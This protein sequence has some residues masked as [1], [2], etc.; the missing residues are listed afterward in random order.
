M[1]SEE[2]IKK[3]KEEIRRLEE[4]NEKLKQAIINTAKDGAD[5]ATRIWISKLE[6]FKPINKNY[7]KR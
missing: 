5:V 4:E 1:S 3:L 2:E 6:G 7:Y